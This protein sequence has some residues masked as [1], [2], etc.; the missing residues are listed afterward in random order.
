MIRASQRIM[1]AQCYHA[2]SGRSRGDQQQVP[3]GTEVVGVAVIA[4]AGHLVVAAVAGIPPW[5]LEV[6]EASA[7][8][9]PAECAQRGCKLV[10]ETGLPRPGTAIDRHP[11]PSGADPRDL[12]GDS[13]DERGAGW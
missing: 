8:R 4:L 2:R 12:G 5:V 1:P 11:E 3:R 13:R 6:V 10:P 9:C 7:Q